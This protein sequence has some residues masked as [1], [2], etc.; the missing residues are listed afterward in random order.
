M[1]FGRKEK[2]Q[3]P[4]DRRQS[5]AGVPVFSRNVTIDRG[6]DKAWQL[7]VTTQRRSGIFARFLP[8]TYTKRLQLD[9]LGCCVVGLIDGHRTVEAIVKAFREQYRLNRREAEL[10]VTE[11]L[12]MLLQRRLIAIA[13]KQGSTPPCTV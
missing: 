10:S 7:V 2:K 13:I 5:L 3:P 6:R 11:F 9:E 8:P 12:K 4:M 1:A